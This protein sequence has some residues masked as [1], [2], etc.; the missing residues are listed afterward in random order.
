MHRDGV[1][2]VAI[3]PGYANFE[4]LARNLSDNRM[5]GFV[6]PLQVA[7]LDG[8]RLEPINYYRSTGAGTSLHAVGPPLDHE[9][10]EFT[11]VETQ[12]VPAYALD[13]LIGA[14]RLPEPTHVKIDVDGT[15][16]P[17]LEG[18]TKT[19][20]S[21]TVKELLVEIVD[22]DRAGTRLSSVQRLFERHGYGL[23]ET[24]SHH[25]DDSK[26]FVA[27]H[28]FRRKSPAEPA[29]RS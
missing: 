17:L 10:N 13:D 2:I 1:R 16:E 28:L 23:A 9:G 24:F 21:G 5:L 20:A 29:S 8:T 27:D 19:L 15:E 3:E 12:M 14:L 26:S 6:I 22:H 25:A 11:P 7:L 18:A 4:S